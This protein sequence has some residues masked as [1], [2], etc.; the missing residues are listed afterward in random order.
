MAMPYNGVI[1][2]K[3]F[4]ASYFFSSGHNNSSFLICASR[5]LLI[6]HEEG[7]PISSC[8]YLGAFVTCL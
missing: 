2:L 4:H 8:L 6:P 5:T 3:I 1:I 7:K